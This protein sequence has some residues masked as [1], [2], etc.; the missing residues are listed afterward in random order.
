[1]GESVWAVRDEDLL[2]DLVDGMSALAFR[3]SDFFDTRFAM[4]HSYKVESDS[5]EII[6]CLTH[7]SMPRNPILCLEDSSR[8]VQPRSR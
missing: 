7:I 2:T 3:A 1:M 8:R 6:G 5:L 4:N